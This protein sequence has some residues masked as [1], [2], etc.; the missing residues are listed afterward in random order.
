M[1]HPMPATPRR[2]PGDLAMWF[3]ILAELAVF[4]LLF[5]ACVYARLQQP[6]LFARQQAGLPLWPALANTVLLLSGSA[7]VFNA[8]CAYAA[9]RGQAGRRWLLACLLCGSGFVLLKGHELGALFAAGI[10]LSS[11][12]FWMFYLSLAG[13]HYLHV[14]LGMVIVAA[15][16]WRA[17]QGAY[18]A[19]HD[20]VETV[21][22]YW[23]MV[24]LVWLVLF[25][26]LYTAR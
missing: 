24:D 20:G 2:V 21:A 12:S 4:S 5:A 3:F 19:N 11:N 17:G 13:F 18:A 8:C 10:N 26:L 7:A 22:A 6:Q 16:W 1:S 9:G 14:L 25:A 15:V 23:H